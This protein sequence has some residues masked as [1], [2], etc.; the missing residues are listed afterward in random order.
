M[1]QLT[2]QQ[3][4]YMHLE[5]ADMLTRLAGKHEL[6]TITVNRY[7]HLQNVYASQ[8]VRNMLELPRAITQCR[9]S[10]QFDTAKHA[11]VTIELEGL[12]TETLEYKYSASRKRQYRIETLEQMPNREPLCKQLIGRGL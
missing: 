10:I 9:I 8:A 11:T 5:Y 2:E 7:G 12:D 6:H 3:Q 1:A 4:T